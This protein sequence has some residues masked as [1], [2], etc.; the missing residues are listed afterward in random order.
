MKSLNKA[1]TA[2]FSKFMSH[3]YPSLEDDAKLDATEM[4]NN[5][6]SADWRRKNELFG[7]TLE[8]VI[9]LAEFAHS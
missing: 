9:N 2:Y 3:P 5:L 1:R 7:L 8:E 6:M 4:L